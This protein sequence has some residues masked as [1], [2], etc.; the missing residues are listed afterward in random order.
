MSSAA[1]ATSSNQILDNAAPVV[2]TAVHC[3]TTLVAGSSLTLD[4]AFTETNPNTNRFYCDRNGAGYRDSAAGT[5]NTADPAPTAISVALNGGSY[6]SAINCV[7]TDDYG[8]TVTTEN[9][10]DRYVK[11]YTPLEPTVN[12]P[13]SNRLDVTINPDPS[14]TTAI[15]YAIYESTT[16]KYVQADG[17]LGAS[18]VW[19][20]IT[21]WGTKTV[22]G[23]T[24]PVAQY[25]FQV[26]SRNSVDNATESN[27]SLSGG[28]INS[29]PWVGYSA[30]DVIPAA[31]VTEATDA[32]GL[33]TVNFRIRDDQNDD[34]ITLDSFAYSDDGSTWYA[35]LNGD[36]SA[37]LGG[38]WPDSGGNKFK[39]TVGWAS[40]VYSFTFNTKH[41]DVTGSH[42]LAA[43]NTANFRVRFKAND[44]LLI[45]AAYG[46]SD[47]QVLDNLAPTVATAII[48]T[49][50]PAGGD[51]LWL[52]AAFTESNPNTNVF[53]YDLNGGGYGAGTA[54]G[55]NT[56]DP[57]VQAIAV[58]ITGADYLSA[59]K[60]VHTDDYGN[61]VTSENLADVFVKPFTPPAPSVNTPTASSVRI[62]VN[63]HAS[64]ASGLNYAIYEVLTGQYVQANGTLGAGAVWQ[65][66][67]TWGTDTVTGL[68]SPVAQYSFKTK[69]RNSMDNLT[70]S[71]LSA[72]GA[73]I[74]SAPVA[75]YSAD[76]VIPAAQVVQSTDGAG[77]I[78]V[79]FRVKD[80]Q[81]DL[82]VLENFGYSDDGGLSWYVPQN[83]D[84][85]AALAGAWPDNSG[86]KFASA[87]AWSGTAYSFTFNTKH[88][89]V[90]GTHPL[91]NV[92]VGNFRV[93]FKAFDGLAAS[94]YVVSDTNSL[95]NVSPTSPSIA[96]ADNQ[97]YTNDA[98]PNLTLSATGADSMRF[99]V[100]AEGWGSWLAYATSK[101]DGSISSGG[102]GLKKVYVEYKDWNGN[103]VAAVYDSTTYDATAPSGPAI[104]I[105]D[106]LGYTQDPAPDMTI[107]A[108]GADSMAF[109]LNGGSWAPY[110]PY[111]ASYSAFNVSAGGDGLKKVYIKFRDWAGNETNG[112]L[113]D[114]TI[115][116]TTKPASSTIVITDN[117]DYTNDATP[118]LALSA[119]GA[120]SMQFQVN[121]E[122]WGSWLAYGT[123]KRDLSMRGSGAGVKKV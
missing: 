121:A 112:A 39:G 11:P 24:P 74:N 8:N 50:A 23:L 89:D 35:P 120:D 72:A 16:V 113:Y 123:S 106:N 19:Q 38:S 5:T 101:S 93:R 104:T 77:V 97:D 91:T 61:T 33:V 65:A 9:T 84:G 64:E 95:D 69:S 71:D 81:Q 26:K 94:A 10:T 28:I 122:G 60:C 29:A 40:S 45:S 87:T 30:T 51:S 99:Q 107:A 90:T 59:V 17:T 56:A 100:N 14:E 79:T 103:S 2:L 46:V 34:Q 54:G 80:A 98:T 75:G 118:D 36:A 85:S 73:I 63:K 3:E 47:N 70:E 88:A 25:R 68:T 117:Q 102:E 82:A 37:A 111:A 4:A 7:H 116:D 32:S 108:T 110:V 12:N 22:T 92:S 15:N 76:T 109:K 48:L 115:F 105:T 57:A 43:A 41:A 53:S 44:G 78:T 67:A 96:V 27:P 6:L 66:I 58:T 83:A 18:A 52:D 31:Q 1:L 42:S 62:T 49:S 13:F 86:G 114:S 55:S 21:A 119:T 20:D